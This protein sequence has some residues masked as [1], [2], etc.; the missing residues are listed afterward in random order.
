MGS[1]HIADMD[2]FELANFNHQVGA[3]LATLGDDKVE[4]LERMALNVNP[5]LHIKTFSNGISQDN[6]DQF[7]HGVDI[8]LDGL[9]FFVLNERKAVFA[10]CAEKGIP[11]ITAAP[12]GMGA[13]FLCFMPGEMTFEEYFRLEGCSEQEQQ[14]RFLKGLSP[15]MLQM[16]YL[17][18]KT[19]IDLE[20]H[21]GPS[22]FMACQ[23]CSG[24]ASANVVKILLGRGDVIAAPHGLHFD[25]YHNRLRKTWRPGGNRNPLQRLGLAMARKRFSSKPDQRPGMGVNSQFRMVLSKKFW[26]WPDGPRV[27]T[28]SSPGALKLSI[29]RT[30]QFTATIPETGVSMTLTAG[31]VR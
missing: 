11:A 12:L 31:Q 19:R 1:F 14:V 29:A 6:L 27:G 20:N 16:S 8:Y 5:E 4:T 30:L 17:A 24:V 2:R 26:T 7:L 28:T 22:T 18:D 23:L 3:T 13:A 25:A 21:K 9:D 10:A 15:S